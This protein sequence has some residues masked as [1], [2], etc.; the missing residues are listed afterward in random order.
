EGITSIGQGAFR[1]CQRLT[2]I[3]LP[4]AVTKIEKT[5]F[6][7]CGA[8]TEIYIP[9]GVV[10]VGT[11]IFEKCTTANITVK[12]KSETAISV[13]SAEYPEVTIVTEF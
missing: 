4:E 6:V 2:K 5:A 10:E 11:G 8:L 3:T 1:L 12:T 9:E 13:I 7:S